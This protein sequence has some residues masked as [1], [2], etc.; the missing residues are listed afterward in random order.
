M[1]Q[2]FRNS[3]YYNYATHKYFKKNAGLTF[4]SNEWAFDDVVYIIAGYKWKWIVFVSKKKSDNL[5]E[6]FVM[7]AVILILNAP[8]YVHK[9]EKSLN[10]FH[11]DFVN[12]SDN[13]FEREKIILINECLKMI[14]VWFI[15]HNK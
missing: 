9:Y 3:I 8:Q 4:H 6:E 15:N 14:M 12:Q 2:M 10:K 7:S 13:W 5:C 11:S 1:K